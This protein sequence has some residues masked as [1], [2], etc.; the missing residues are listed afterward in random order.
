MGDV[1]SASSVGEISNGA[2]LLRRG[3][4]PYLGKAANPLSNGLLLR[5][6]LHTLFDLGL[7]GVAPSTF[8]LVLS[9]SLRNGDYARY[10]GKQ[11]SVPRQPS[12]QPA[13]R[14]LKQ[15]LATHKLAI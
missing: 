8:A 2:G 3:I 11:I 15:H 13:E 5:S 6:D 1:L 9:Q 14:A 10:A 12:D 7:I 4:T